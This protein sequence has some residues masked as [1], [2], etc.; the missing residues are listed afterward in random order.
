MI[1]QDAVIIIKKLVGAIVHSVTRIDI[2]RQ[3]DLKMGQTNLMV[4]VWFKRKKGSSK[5]DLYHEMLFAN[6]IKRERTVIE[7]IE[8]I[9]D[10][11][12]EI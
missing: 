4:N 8:K 2:E 9:Q 12:H 5:A 3:Y 7:L 6:D 1:D 10:N 11:L